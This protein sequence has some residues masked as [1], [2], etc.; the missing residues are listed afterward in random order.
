MSD[1]TRFAIVPT[2]TT[3]HKLRA[4]VEAKYPE[5]PIVISEG[6]GIRADSKSIRTKIPAYEVLWITL[7]IK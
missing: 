5:N 2:I 7:M 1:P 3:S 4:P 6:I